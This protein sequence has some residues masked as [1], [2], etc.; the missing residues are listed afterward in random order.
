MEKEDYEYSNDIPEDYDVLRK[1]YIKL[2]RKYEKLESMNKKMKAKNS[3]LNK[4]LLEFE[5]ANDVLNEKKKYLKTKMKE[6][7]K[8]GKILIY[9]CRVIRI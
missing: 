2:M 1:R 8:V 7:K 4:Y 5:D 3:K 9:N 6:M